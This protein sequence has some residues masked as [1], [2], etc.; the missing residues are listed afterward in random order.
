MFDP[1]GVTNSEL[2]RDLSNH[3]QLS[4]VY[5]KERQ[6]SL[7]PDAGRDRADRTE[8]SAKGREVGK[9]DVREEPRNAQQLMS[10]ATTR[11]TWNKSDS[12]WTV[13]NIPRYKSSS[14]LGG[15]ASC[16]DS[17]HKNAS[18]KKIC[19]MMLALFGITTSDAID[20][21]K[22]DIPTTTA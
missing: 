16:C 5:R 21:T 3:P 1:R 2:R 17:N 13:H 12:L 22:G 8:G 10:G 20:L 14:E 6:A 7:R 4:H 9:N 19:G 15:W 18:K 11:C